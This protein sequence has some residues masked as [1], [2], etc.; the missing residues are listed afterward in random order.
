MKNLIYILIL[1]VLISCSSTP[2]IF[3]PK[4]KTSEL[5]ISIQ[6]VRSE[7]GNVN[8]AMYDSK[9]SFGSMEKVIVAAYRKAAVPESNFIIK[10]KFMPGQYAI[11]AFH[12]ENGNGR[13]DMSKAG[14]PK[15]G[16]GASNLK[17]VAAKPTWETCVFEVNQEKMVIPIIMNYP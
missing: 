10:G 8:F 6:N 17:K 15:E 9:E 14:I 7:G 3:Q 5:T 13:I 1:L 11:I 12:D 4:E 2:V 16:F